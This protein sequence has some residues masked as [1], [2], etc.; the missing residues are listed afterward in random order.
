MARML[1]DLM[2]GNDPSPL[3]LPTRLVIRE[4]A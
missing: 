3:I 4:S 1:L 2:A